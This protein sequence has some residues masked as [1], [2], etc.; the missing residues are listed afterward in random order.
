MPHVVDKGFGECFWVVFIE[1]C[2]RFA[3]FN[4]IMRKETQVK[5]LTIKSPVPDR[6]AS[7]LISGIN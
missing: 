1:N 6:K 3:Y 2:R 4:S 7:G 5:N